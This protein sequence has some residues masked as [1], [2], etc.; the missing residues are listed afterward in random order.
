MPVR[1]AVDIVQCAVG[2]LRV[3]NVP[4]QPHL[5]PPPRPRV[6]GLR[7]ISALLLPGPGSHWS[8]SWPLGWLPRLS[9]DL[10]RHYGL[11]W[12]YLG[13]PWLLPL[14]LILTSVPS[15]AWGLPFHHGLTQWPGPLADPGC[16]F[17][18]SPAFLDVGPNLIYQGPCPGITFGSPPLGEQL[19][20]SAPQHN[21]VTGCHTAVYS[22]V[23]S[24]YV[25]LVIEH[26][27]GQN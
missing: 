26:F 11:T 23:W 19:G 3:L 8:G 17:Q 21:S 9:S 12:R 2:A 4:D 22:S 15:S 18:A 27:K 24:L 20:L 5:G 6:Q 10:P 1:C 25:L 7:F 16:L 13:W 14:D